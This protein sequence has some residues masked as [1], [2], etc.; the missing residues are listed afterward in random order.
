MTV[1]V[2][3]RATVLTVLVVAAGP[4]TEPARIM[5]NPPPALPLLL[6]PVVAHPEPQA[7]TATS[8]KPA[9]PVVPLF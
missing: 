9:V 1:Y 8:A 3:L 2:A 5:I 4:V 7:G 6:M